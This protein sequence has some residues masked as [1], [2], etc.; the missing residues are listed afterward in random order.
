M[1]KTKDAASV[2]AKWGRRTASAG[3]E[4]L[5]GV[6]NPRTS[7][8]AAAR[9]AA[10]AYNAGVQA[11]IGRNAFEKGVA[12]AGDTAWQAGATDKGPARFSEGVQIGTPAY[13]EGV[14]KVLQTINSTQ[15]PPRG[16]TG[17]PQNI[18]RVAAIATALRKMKTGAA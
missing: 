6:Q 15:L 16:P 1:A 17:S 8:S 3:Q 4:Y 11:A 10:P 18:Q 5:E 12:A 2:S 13:Q 14:A 7:W 9:A